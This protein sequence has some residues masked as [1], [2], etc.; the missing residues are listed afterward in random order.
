MKSSYLFLCSNSTQGYCLK[1]RIFGLARK[2]LSTVTEI[3][4]GNDLFLYNYRS[5][6]LFGPFKAVSEGGEKL[7]PRAWG[8]RYPAQVRVDY[9]EIKE[10]TAADRRFPFLKKRPIKLS[11]EQAAILMK[12]FEKAASW[13]EIIFE[14][15]SIPHS[16]K[17]FAAHLDNQRIPFIRASQEIEDFSS[18][19]KE[20]KAK[21]PDFLILTKDKPFFVEVKPNL[22]R[23]DMPQLVLDIEE[24]NKLN[25]FQLLT[26]VETLVMFPIDVHGTSWKPLRP[27]WV[28]AHALKRRMKGRDVFVVNVR[29]LERIKLPF[30]LER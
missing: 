5:N 10:I 7:E 20:M 14:A 3:R 17:L 26:G 22:V 16:E 29:R 25:Q 1:N 15:K 21:R 8:G 23:F 19:L 6:R 24:V 2:Y 30:D 28:V 27:S 12:A 9:E 13:G 18:V 4:K 11:S